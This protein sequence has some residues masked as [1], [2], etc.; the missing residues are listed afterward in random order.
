MNLVNVNDYLGNVAQKVRKCPTVTL[1]RAYMRALREWCQ[2]TQW[3]RTNVPG[4]TVA[5]IAQ[6]SLGNDPQL[7]IVGIFAMQAS[8]VTTASAAGPSIW[9][10]AASDSSGWNPNVQPEQPTRY[11]YLPEAQFAIYPTPDQV[12]NLSITVILAPKE[13]AVQAPQAPLQKYSN[14]IEEGAL[15][16]L[17]DIP[18]EPWSDK[19]AAVMNQRAFQSGISNGKAEAQ[20]NYNTGAQ[21]AR[22]RSFGGG[23]NNRY[24]GGYSW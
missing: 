23:F 12:Y 10:L 22:A 20:R 3:L 19:A 13:G 1:R 8:L 21:R 4:A 6:Y 18:G 5:D 2:Q 14:D 24:P 15:A 11:C 17:R 16:Y 7:D 9:G